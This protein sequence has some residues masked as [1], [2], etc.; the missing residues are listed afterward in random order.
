VTQ[1]PPPLVQAV[2][3][4][5]PTLRP[6][7]H[8][9]LPGTHPLL[10]T[11]AADQVIAIARGAKVGQTSWSQVAL[12]GGQDA[13]RTAR[14]PCK[15]GVSTSFVVMATLLWSR[16]SEVQV[17]CMIAVGCCA[18]RTVPAARRDHLR[19][20]RRPRAFLGVTLPCSLHWL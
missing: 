9:D 8:P 20:A 4:A 10:R 11:G 18:A 15:I 14:N 5:R 17:F 2:P 16:V 7:E 6:V 19:L 3:A 13:R 1:P 12:N